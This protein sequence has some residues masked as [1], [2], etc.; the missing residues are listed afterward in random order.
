MERMNCEEAMLALLNARENGTACCNEVE[1]HIQECEVC[2]REVAEVDQLFD[3]INKEVVLPAPLS[4]RKAFKR[5]LAEEI[6][7]SQKT[8]APRSVIF[9]F[10]FLT[11]AAACVLLMAGIGVGYLLTRTKENRPFTKTF[12]GNQPDSVTATTYQS[13]SD[14][15]EMINTSVE[16]S[17]PDDSLLATLTRILASDKN[18]NVRMA[19]LYALTKYADDPTVH[20]H[21]VSCLTRETEPVIQVL[22]IN[23]LMEKKG[24][25]AID[26]IQNLIKNGGTRKEVK[27]VAETKLRSL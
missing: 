21:L 6:A 25:G 9:P 8:I 1:Q 2:R 13:S 14:R 26:A 15:I 23:L 4:I 19:A 17:A 12:T 3:A 18:S 5:A 20:K 22:L 16:T 11:A 27:M 10:R 24:P 7:I